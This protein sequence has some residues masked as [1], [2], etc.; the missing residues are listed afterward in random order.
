MFH[1]KTICAME[2]LN[3]NSYLRSNN[4]HNQLTCK[5]QFTLKMYNT[6]HHQ[7]KNGNCNFFSLQ[8][9]RYKFTILRNKDIIGGIS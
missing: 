5:E 3:T 6:F 8:I 1:Y 4:N 2:S 9:A 7:I